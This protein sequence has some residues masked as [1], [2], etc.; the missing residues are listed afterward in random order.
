MP[1]SIASD[2]CFFEGK[3]FFA[4]PDFFGGTGAGLKS[5][6]GLKKRDWDWL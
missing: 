3:G 4:L 1:G 6:N 2:S 5:R